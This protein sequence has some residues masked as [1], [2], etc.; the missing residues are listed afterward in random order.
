MMRDA[1]RVIADMIDRETEYT[2]HQ[3]YVK[4]KLFE[5]VD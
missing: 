3:T 4:A 5:Q 1:K 2:V